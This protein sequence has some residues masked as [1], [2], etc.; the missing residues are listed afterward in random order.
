M[1]TPNMVVCATLATA[2]VQ[3]FVD[4]CAQVFP[5]GVCTVRCNAN[6]GWHG[7]PKQ[8]FCPASNTNALQAPLPKISWPECKM[9]QAVI[10]HPAINTDAS[11][12]G[13]TREKDFCDVLGS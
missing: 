10:N 5:G 6:A 13:P 1:T 12:P 4:D 11:T 7:V 9:S 3:F 2:E 8:F